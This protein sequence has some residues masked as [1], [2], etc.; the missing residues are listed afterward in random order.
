MAARSVFGQSRKRS[1]GGMDRRETNEESHADY[2][3]CFKKIEYGIVGTGIL[4]MS[5]L[6]FINVMMRAILNDSLMWAEELTRYILIWVTCIG[7]DLCI[8]AGSHVRM[9]LLHIK[10][11]PKAVKPLLCVTYVI[12]IVACLLLTRAGIVLVRNVYMTGAFISSMPW[13]RTWVIDLAFPLFAI[14]S[15]KDLTWLFV[16][17]LTHKNETITAIG[18]ELE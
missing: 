18:G 6:I 16:L 1:V 4:F 12:S 11:P 9:D 10:L 7:S 13:L 2:G 8:R 3:R 15:V 14:L 5:F 17:N